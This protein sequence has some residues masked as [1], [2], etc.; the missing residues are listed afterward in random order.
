MKAAVC[1]GFGEPL[2]VEEVE[3]RAPRVG[4]VSVRV[5]AC[6]ICHSDIAAMRGLWGGDL[7]AVYGHEAA[8]VVEDVGPGVETFASGDHVVVTLVRS[9]G[10]CALCLRGEPALCG[11]W[12]TMPISQ[13]PPI[14]TADG[15]TVQQGLRTAAFAERALV[16]VSQVVSIPTDVDLSC[17]CLLACG[18]VTGVGAV[19]TTARVE[20]GASAA[21]IGTGGVGV[22]VV[23]GLALAGAREI[24]AVD[25]VDSKLAAAVAFGATHAVNGAADGLPDAVAELTAG[26]GLDYVFVTAASIA[27]VEQGLD[28]VGRGGTLVLVGMPPSGARASFDA[29]RITDQGLRIL[30]SKVGSVRP[31][32]DIPHLVE[33]YRQGR[34]RLDEL[35][36][37]RFPLEGVNDAVSSVE[38]GEA[39]RPVVVP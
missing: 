22:N 7:P 2:R 18:V 4:E 12:P 10:R 16:H 17:A 1:H 9:C 37:G 31:T 15:R 39:L 13:H 11:D 23:Q 20:A 32:L 24:V 3:L 26:R 28:L 5:A 14:A 8:G 34:L 25:I 6:A 27:A 19:L 21:V 33:L 35:I 30:G 36:S 38:H 29:E